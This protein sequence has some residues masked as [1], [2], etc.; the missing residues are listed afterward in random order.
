VGQFKLAM[1]FRAAEPGAHISRLR[2][3]R[4]LGSYQPASRQPP[5]CGECAA[6][7][8]KRRR[9]RVAL[10]TVKQLPNRGLTSAGFAPAAGW[11]P[12]S[13]LR[14]SR[15]FA[16]SVRPVHASDGA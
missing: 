3:S 6:G 11:A 5:V 9:V 14:A 16:A 1:R 15:R 4:G 7:P 12:I 8:R 10:R 2:A 13:R